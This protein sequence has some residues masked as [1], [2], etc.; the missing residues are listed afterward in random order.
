M[1]RGALA[2]LA[3]LIAGGCGGSGDDRS[4]D[5]SDTSG[6]R[7]GE[8]T[9]LSAGDVTSLDPGAWFYGYDY[10]ALAGTTQR[11]L[12]GFEPAATTPT[13]DLAAAMPRIAAGGLTVTIEL[14]PNIRY[15]PPLQ[16]RIVTSDDVKYAI[17]RAFTP[18][19]GNAYAS[20]YYAPIIGTQAFASGA[21]GEIEGIETPDATTLV[22]KLRRASGVIASGQALALPATVPV[23]KDYAE[24]YDAP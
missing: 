17:E 1:R 7:G 9:I 15:S 5:V 20:T 11:A 4:L 16:E 18:G 2:L 21:A 13:P 22:L 8:V 23:P 12:Y 10:Q 6:K 19:V 3:A 24:R 14:K